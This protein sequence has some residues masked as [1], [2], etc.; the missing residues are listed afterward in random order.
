M[1]G[2]LYELNA[3]YVQSDRDVYCR[4]RDE[5]AFAALNESTL[6]TTTANNKSRGGGVCQGKPV[7]TLLTGL[8]RTSPKASPSH[9]N[10][11]SRERCTAQWQHIAEEIKLKHPR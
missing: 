1:A 8:M 2:R 4:L 7:I 10:S 5:T 3:G 9:N 11:D 6:C